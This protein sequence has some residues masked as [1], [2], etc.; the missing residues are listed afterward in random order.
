MQKILII[1]TVMFLNSCSEGRWVAG[2]KRHFE[3]RKEYKLKKSN[4]LPSTK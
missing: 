2:N 1:L 3:Q 4:E